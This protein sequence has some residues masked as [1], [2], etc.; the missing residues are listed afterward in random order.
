MIAMVICSK[1]SNAARLEV[2]LE[3]ETALFQELHVG[4]A[5]GDQFFLEIIQGPASQ[6]L[7]QLFGV[8][9]V[10]LDTSLEFHPLGHV[11]LLVGNESQV[12][13]RRAY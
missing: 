5:I 10:E 4:F 8:P 13:F 9:L 7:G 12:L 11:E 1:G 3:R 6:L 2:A